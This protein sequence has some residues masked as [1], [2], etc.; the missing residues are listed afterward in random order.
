MYRHL[1]AAIVEILLI[2]MVGVVVVH[3]VV[4]MTLLSVAAEL[5]VW[6]LL[7]LVVVCWLALERVL[8]MSI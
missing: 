5:G 7:R 3:H 1:H 8:E 4:L 2:A 6:I